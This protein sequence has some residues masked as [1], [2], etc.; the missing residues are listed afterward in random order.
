MS[1]SDTS[2]YYRCDACDHATFRLTE[3]VAHF[4]YYGLR[5]SFSYNGEYP[6]FRVSE[7]EKFVCPG[8]RMSTS[9]SGFT[10][11]HR[12]THHLRGGCNG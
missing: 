9:G 5:H 4:A 11:Q 1:Q 3:A 7:W 8:S 2:T 6:V 12:H 10:D